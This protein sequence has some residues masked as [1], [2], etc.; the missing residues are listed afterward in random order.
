MSSENLKGSLETAWKR[1]RVRIRQSRSRSSDL[2]RSGLLH[3]RSA[4][5]AWIDRRRGRNRWREEGE[6]GYLGIG[7]GASSRVSGRFSSRVLGSV[8]SA[9][10]D[11]FFFFFPRETELQTGEAEGKTYRANPWAQPKLMLSMGS[12]FG[13][14]ETSYGF[15]LIKK[16]HFS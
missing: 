16:S 12:W 8:S 9:W 11:R 1:S 10:M 14:P 15:G 3:W 5:E 7:I 6:E 2:E 4:R 13:Y